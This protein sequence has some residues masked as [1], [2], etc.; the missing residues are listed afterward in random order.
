MKLTVSKMGEYEFMP[1]VIKVANGY[2]CEINPDGSVTATWDEMD[3][4]KIYKNADKLK[5]DV[6]ILIENE[7]I[8]TVEP[9]INVNVEDVEAE[10]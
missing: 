7:D 2:L 8:F 3:S 1:K 4:V 6:S 9:I 10:A 5:K